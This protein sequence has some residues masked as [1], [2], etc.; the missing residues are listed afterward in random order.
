MGNLLPPSNKKDP[1]DD[2]PP[3]TQDNSLILLKKLPSDVVRRVHD[4]VKFEGARV[5]T[6]DT[7]FTIRFLIANES[8]MVSSTGYSLA[9]WNGRELERTTVC[10]P[11]KDVKI[12]S[13]TGLDEHFWCGFT[14]GSIRIYDRQL[15]RVRY[16]VAHKAAVVA[17][18]H[19]SDKSAV[20]SYPS[21]HSEERIG[22]WSPEGILLSTVTMPS[23][24]VVS[25]SNLRF[26]MG[27]QMA[28]L[29]DSSE[30]LWSGPPDVKLSSP[31]ATSAVTI[32]NSSS[33]L[34]EE[35]AVVFAT[36]AVPVSSF[37]TV[38]LSEGVPH[39]CDEN[40]H[41]CDPSWVLP[42]SSVTAACYFKGRLVLVTEDRKM[43]VF[44]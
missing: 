14:D 37:N 20:Y 17:L 22:I 39:I 19:N 1:W 25:V 26:V 16:A 29:W 10:S 28:S 31:G 6:S 15:N 41:A 24:N 3:R 35:E 44:Q 43:H 2:L 36:R 8:Y 34:F 11:T 42:V 4:F 7:P 27:P 21:V 32:T 18:G 33:P 5:F 38:F 12:E 13:M 30:L 40:G 9:V 23:D